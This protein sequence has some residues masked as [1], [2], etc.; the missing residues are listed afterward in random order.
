M[1]SAPRVFPEC[2]ILFGKHHRNKLCTRLAYSGEHI[3]RLSHRILRSEP[4]SCPPA[5]D[6]SSSCSSMIPRS[7][8]PYFHFAPV[9]RFGDL[10]LVPNFSAPTADSLLGISAFPGGPISSS[11]HKVTTNPV[12]MPMRLISTRAKRASRDLLIRIDWRSPDGASNSG[13]V[14][15]AD[16]LCVILRASRSLPSTNLTRSIPE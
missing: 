7:P 6:S 13:A 1:I 14:P 3:F 11:R 9:K 8:R 5:R 4:T 12:L 2:H 15:A 16:R 10:I